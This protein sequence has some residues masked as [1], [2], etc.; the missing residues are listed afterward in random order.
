MNTLVVY[1]EKIKNAALISWLIVIV[2]LLLGFRY[3]KA[4]IAVVLD[5]LHEFFIQK[6]NIGLEK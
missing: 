6:N 1:I 4:G 3:I 2:L 5:K